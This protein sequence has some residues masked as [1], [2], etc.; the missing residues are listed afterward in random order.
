MF[1]KEHKLGRKKETQLSI[2]SGRQ[3]RVELEAN[4]KKYISR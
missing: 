4:I 1:T 2:S 3:C